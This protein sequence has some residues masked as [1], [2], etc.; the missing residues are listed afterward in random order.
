MEQLN[1]VK[2]LLLQYPL[3]G[4]QALQV[5]LN[6]GRPEGCIL[7]PQGLRVLDRREDVQGNVTYRL[8]QSFL[9]RRVAFAGENAAHWL[10]Q[11][12]NWL[13]IQPA[14]ALE[15]V[16]GPKLRL[17]AELGRLTNAKQPGT[18]IYEVKIHAQY[19]KE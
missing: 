15:S 8:E 16:F 2:N 4:G 17:W 1:A 5:D 12:Q 14:G 7:F 6:D 11:L 10:Q 9:L 13:L 3:W 19:E 18:G